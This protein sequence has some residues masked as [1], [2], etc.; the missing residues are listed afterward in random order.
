M[1]FIDIFAEYFRNDDSN[2]QTKF[3]VHITSNIFKLTKSYNHRIYT[4]T[5]LPNLENLLYPA[6]IRGTNEH[7]SI[8]KK[9]TH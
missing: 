5:T 8:Q 9:F 6:K 4:I 1:N 3:Q 2:L 7:K